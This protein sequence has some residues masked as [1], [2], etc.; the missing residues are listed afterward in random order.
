M[1]LACNF[2]ILWSFHIIENLRFLRYFP[3]IYSLHAL[4][5]VWCY[6]LALI[7]LDPLFLTIDLFSSS[8][9]TPHYFA[10]R[11]LYHIVSYHF[12]SLMHSP[13]ILFIYILGKILCWDDL[14]CDPLGLTRSPP[15][16]LSTLGS[17]PNY[18]Q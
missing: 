9:T 13:I 4:D 12:H 14:A 10:P 1:I 8:L 17:P 18:N 6:R 5:L 11:T 3:L 2:H 15:N 7:F 16:I